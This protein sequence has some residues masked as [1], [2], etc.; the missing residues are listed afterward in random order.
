MYSRVREIPIWMTDAARGAKSAVAMR[1]MGLPPSPSLS[2]PPPKIA[3]HW[4]ILAIM[5]M[6]LAKLATMVLMR[7]SR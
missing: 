6:A 5:A 4:A 2:R 3:A 1:A 7:M